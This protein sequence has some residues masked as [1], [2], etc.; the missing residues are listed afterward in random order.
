MGTVSPMVTIACTGY[1]ALEAKA[2]LVKI[3]F[4]LDP[5]DD[6]VVVAV[7]CCGVCGSDLHMIDNDWGFLTYPLVPGHEIIG[8]VVSKGENA[9]AHLQLGMR[10]GIGHLSRTCSTCRYCLDGDDSICENPTPT[11]SP[12]GHRGGFASHVAASAKF[13]FPIPESIQSA[14]A[15]PLLCGGITVYAPLL[16]YKVRPGD[17]VGIIGVGGLGHLAIQFA[18]AWGTHVTV[19]STSANKEGL[20]KSLG[21]HSFVNSTDEA[22][23]AQCVDTLDFIYYVVPHDVDFELYLSLLRRNGKLCVLASSGK[24]MQVQTTSLF[25]NHKSIVGRNIGSAHW[26]LKMLEF[27]AL[28]DIKAVVE[29]FPMEQI[30][31]TIEL[32]KQNKVQFR[33]VLTNES[34]PASGPSRL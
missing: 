17:R 24:P 10:V 11:V 12:P 9:P 18:K 7:E 8:T 5:A 3:A 31:E 4:E 29:T 1:A 33:A 27:A 23:M 22:A 26:T 30:N 2:P 15:A 6:E 28:H 16:A 34:D 14:Q 19:F 32:V 21:A 25:L 13:V 20:A